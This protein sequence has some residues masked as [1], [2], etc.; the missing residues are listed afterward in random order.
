MET[1]RETGAC[2]SPLSSFQ[3][4]LGL[5]TLSLRVDKQTANAKA[6][7]EWLAKHP[8]VAWVSREC[9]KLTKYF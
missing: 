1:L 8:A 5:E 2:L 6:L 3:L 7:A 9:T 4:I